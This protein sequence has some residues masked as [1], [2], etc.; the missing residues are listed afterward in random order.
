M[1]THT[2]IT[3]QL[4]KQAGFSVKS[5]DTQ[6]EVSLSRPINSMEIMRVISREQL[7]IDQSQLQYT[8]RGT[9]IINL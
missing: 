6:V 5:N 1:T 4:F 9:I 8:S 3:A 7:P 2:Q